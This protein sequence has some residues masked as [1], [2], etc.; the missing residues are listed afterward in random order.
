MQLLQCHVSVSELQ[1]DR[2]RSAE[3]FR[4]FMDKEFMYVVTPLAFHINVQL[5]SD[6]Y[7]LEKG[8]GNPE[9]N[10]MKPGMFMYQLNS[11]KFVGDVVT[12][13]TEFPSYENENN[14]K[15]PGP[16]LFRISKLNAE[17]NLDEIK[18]M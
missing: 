13:S 15:K 14:E 11:P 3:L 6:V 16:L 8:F 9:V 5:S 17:S 7:R 12:I 2:R 18:M 4:E 10:N 1:S